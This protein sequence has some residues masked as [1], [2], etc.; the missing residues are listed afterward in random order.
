MQKT[1]RALGPPIANNTNQRH[2]YCEQTGAAKLS[3]IKTI[4]ITHGRAGFG[5]RSKV[6]V[7]RRKDRS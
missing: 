5:V 1:G 4:Q 2:E 3:G 6:I 7:T